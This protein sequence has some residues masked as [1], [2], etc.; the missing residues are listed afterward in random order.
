MKL[1]NKQYLRRQKALRNFFNFKDLRSMLQAGLAMSRSR[2]V[3]RD[4]YNTLNQ[5]DR[6]FAA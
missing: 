2:V 3:K 5:L 1:R 6:Q 4:I